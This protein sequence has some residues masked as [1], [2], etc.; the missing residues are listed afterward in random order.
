MRDLRVLDLDQNF[1]TG[2][3]PPSIASLAKLE[4]LKLSRNRLHGTVP[5]KLGMPPQVP[6][7]FP[8]S[9]QLHTLL[10]H[11]NVCL[12]GT[13]PSALLLPSQPSQYPLQVLRVDQTG[14]RGNW[15]ETACSASV[16]SNRY[17]RIR[18]T[19]TNGVNIPD[20]VFI[21]LLGENAGEP[22]HGATIEESR[23]GGPLIECP[24]C[25]CCGI[26]GWEGGGESDPELQCDDAEYTQEGHQY[27][28]KI[29]DPFERCPLL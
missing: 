18:A 7:S 25:E 11:S 8:S 2:S 21:E 10:L 13:L 20:A 15:S 22:V 24:C 29:V 14:I 16:S 26:L 4:S 12:S 27:H 19:C 28:D 6:D 23:V 17:V 3:I 1:L 9:S 5:P